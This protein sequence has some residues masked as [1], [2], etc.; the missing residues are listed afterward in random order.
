MKVWGS[1]MNGDYG[2]SFALFEDEE[3]AKEY[4]EHIKKTC[5]PE[6]NIYVVCLDV[7]EKKHEPFEINDSNKEQFYNDH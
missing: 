6:V 2:Y 5:T 4:S 7:T 3:D 1:I